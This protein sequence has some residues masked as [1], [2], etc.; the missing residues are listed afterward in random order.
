MISRCIAHVHSLNPEAE[1]VIVDGGDTDSI[2]SIAHGPGVSF[3]NSEPG[4]GTQ[5]NAGAA[6]ASGD[7]LVFLHADTELPVDSFKILEEYFSKNNVNIGTFKLSFDINHWLLRLYCLPCKLDLIFTRFGDQCI[8]VRR[9]FFESL[10]GF[11]NWKLY[12]DLALVNRA[13]KQTRI[14]RFP[15]RVRTSARRF[16]RNGIIRQQLFNIW[17]TLLYFLGVSPD[18]LAF[19][20]EHAVM[21]KKAADLII[22][23]RFP[24]AGRVK[25]RLARSLGEKKAMELYRLCAEH[26]FDECRKL[27][28]KTRLAVFLDNKEDIE[29]GM[30]WVGPWFD[31]FIQTGDNL[32]QRLAHALETRFSHGA[33]KVIVMA[34]DTPGISKKVITSAI[35][36]LDS[37]DIVIGPCYDGGYYLIGMKKTYPGLFTG[38][39]WSTDRVYRQTMDAI[40]KERLWVHELPKLIDI[41]TGED[42][43]KWVRENEAGNHLNLKQFA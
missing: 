21:K 18:K 14:F 5:C 36:S 16:L 1:I 15:G 29:P 20:Y 26:T 39:N 40:E 22:F 23:A 34:S 25:S 7:I 24:Q 33:Q 27:H 4:R 43:N 35:K 31:V 6:V 37:H 28:T 2:E 19:K 38:I 3:T 13:R 41:D 17:L 12:E 8:V 11:P 32:G 9:S 42:L 30:R 10:G